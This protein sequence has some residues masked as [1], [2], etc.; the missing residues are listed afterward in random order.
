LGNYGHLSNN[1]AADFLCSVISPKLKYV[2]LGH[3]SQENNTPYQALE[4]IHE[5][6]QNN[7]F[8]KNLPFKLQVAPA[9]VP[10]A[11]ICLE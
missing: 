2:F 3:L 9:E 10:G 6:L 8:P 11:L 7:G 4:T 5:T 1:T